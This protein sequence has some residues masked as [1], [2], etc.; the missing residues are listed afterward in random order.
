M[1]NLSNTLVVEQ[2]TIT[3]SGT[4]WYSEIDS[5]L[6]SSILHDPSDRKFVAVQ[7]AHGK[8]P[9]I[10]NACDGDWKEIQ[11]KITLIW[12]DSDLLKV[13]QVFP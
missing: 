7:H 2:V 11:D 1:Q 9:P 8:S 5:Q 4:D 6:T 3:K 13:E 12:L 10:V